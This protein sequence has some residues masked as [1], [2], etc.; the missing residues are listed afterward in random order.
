MNLLLYSPQTLPSIGGLQYVVHYWAAAL[1]KEG[2]RVVVISDTAGAA[3]QPKS[4]PVL[5]NP[6]F[7]EKR[8]A[9]QQSDVLLCFDVALKGLPFWI[10]SGKPLIFSHQSG[11]WYEDSP[12]PLRQRIKRWVANHLATQ[13]IACSRFIAKYY[14]NTTVIYNP[15][16][17]DLFVPGAENIREA[18]TLLF[19]GRL[20]TD[21][22]CDLLLEAIALLQKKHPQRIFRLWIAGDG[23]EKAA[24]QQQAKSM[25]LEKAVDFLGFLSQEEL[26]KQMHRCAVMVVP[27]RMEPMG[28]IAAEGLA[29]G[30]TMVLADY[31]GL[32]EV[33]GSFC[34]Y[35]NTGD[36]ASLSEAIGRALDHP[37]PP[38]TA[39]LEQ[40]LAQFG[41][42]YSV[43]ALL[44]VLYTVTDKT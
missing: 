39:D 29:A 12:M 9:L 8:K 11:L 22:G 37:L 13:N 35:F 18:D 24:L 40:H 19:S 14:K 17:L 21:K 7:F 15:V 25:H 26:V 36:A 3:R 33:G 10:G 32:P 41:I 4:Y 1:H 5:E 2:H 31:G 16:R 42:D 44:K 20:V 27:S 23:P 34:H 28:M 30:C 6:G 38:D 43:N